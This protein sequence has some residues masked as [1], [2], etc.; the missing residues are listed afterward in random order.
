MVPGRT[1][2]APG[3]W[4]QG[5][6]VAHWPWERR[7]RDTA[8]CALVAAPADGIVCVIGERWR[9]G[10]VAGRR[11]GGVAGA[12]RQ[13]STCQPTAQLMRQRV[14]ARP[15]V[16]PCVRAWPGRA[17]TAALPTVLVRLRSRPSPGGSG[18]ADEPGCRVLQRRVLPG[19]PAG[20]PG[21][22]GA[23]GSG[24]RGGAQLRLGAA[25]ASARG[26]D[27]PPAA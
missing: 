3:H 7:T 23:A 6:M 10:G 1:R 21:G 24:V 19:A 8:R 26:H 12:P 2:C 17:R 4:H 18:P 14:P 13:R 11:G 15:H 20:P 27:R 16:R 9:G 5:G 25:G 22:A